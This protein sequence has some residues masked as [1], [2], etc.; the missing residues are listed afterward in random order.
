M[1]HVK[2][3][4]INFCARCHNKE[5]CSDE[6]DRAPSLRSLQ[7]CGATVC[8]VQEGRRGSET[9][10]NEP[11]GVQSTKS[12]SNKEDTRNLPVNYF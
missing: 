10:M 12:C 9:R 4:F 2:Y 7:T 6:K 3:L 1:N 8:E 11:L 5:I